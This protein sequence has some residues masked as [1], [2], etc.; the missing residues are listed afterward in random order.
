M[1]EALFEALKERFV[2][3]IRKS[4]QPCPLIGPKWLQAYPYGRPADFRFFGI[5]KLA[6]ATG[7]PTQKV[8]QMLMR[9]VSFAGLDVDVEI[10]GGLLIDI[11]EQ[12]ADRPEKPAKPERKPRR[13]SE[14]D[15]KAKPK[16]AAAPSGQAAHAGE[17]V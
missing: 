6:K 5:R 4:F 16:P 2:K 3:G 13:A 17:T 9:N 15:A 1:N 8:V 14:P 10:K 7:R 12:G 11:N